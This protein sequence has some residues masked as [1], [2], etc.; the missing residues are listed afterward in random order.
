MKEASGLLPPLLIGQ[1][2]PCL[3]SGFWQQ[4]VNIPVKT[5]ISPLSLFFSFVFPTLND[6]YCSSNLFRCPRVKTAARTLLA[7]SL[8]P[9]NLPL[10]PFLR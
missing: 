10:N 1:L 4:Q 6:H 2:L 9:L 8:K 3:P 5:V 7:Y